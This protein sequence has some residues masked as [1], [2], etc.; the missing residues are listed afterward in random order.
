MSRSSPTADA[1]ARRAG[2]VLDKLFKKAKAS[3]EFEYVC[4]LLRIRGMEAAGWDPLL[5]THELVAD[6]LGLLEAPLRRDTQVRLALLTYCHITEVEAFYAVLENMLRAIDGQRSSSQPFYHLYR[7]RK[8]TDG[9]FD[10]RIPPSAKRVVDCVRTHA[11]KLGETD[12]GGLLDE[13]FDSD[14]RNSFFHADYVL[15]GGEYRTRNGSFR[16]G[17]HVS[18][19]LDVNDLMAVVESGVGFYAAFMTVYLDHVRSYKQPK[20]VK[21][22]LHGAENPPIDVELMVDPGRGVCGF[23]SPSPRIQTT[24]S[25]PSMH[26]RKVDPNDSAV[27]SAASA[28]A[29]TCGILAV[30]IGEPKP[31]LF[32]VYDAVDELVACLWGTEKGVGDFDIAVAP[33]ARRQRLATRLADKYLTDYGPVLTGFEVTINNRVL[34]GVARKHGFAPSDR[35]AKTWTRSS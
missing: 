4:A 13:M 23:R 8:K 7:K 16:R 12:V 14:I 3:D 20:I 27:A 33:H 26:V 17:K 35:D 19:A 6:A 24:H 28:L 5:E 32:G 31:V 25:E 15:H 21:G 10:K 34:E 22:R 29:E 30:Q 2:A 11:E 1:F 9:Q 18:S